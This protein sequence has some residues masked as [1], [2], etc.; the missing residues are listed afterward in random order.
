M[1]KET[2]LCGA[3]VMAMTAACCSDAQET[4]L[5]RPLQ[6][7]RKLPQRQELKRRQRQK[8]MQKR[9]RQRLLPA[10]RLR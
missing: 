4:A 6:P 8:R 10:R 1:K 3:A 9:K 5:R 2:F 7:E